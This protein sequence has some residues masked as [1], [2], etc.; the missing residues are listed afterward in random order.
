MLTYRL[1][2]NRDRQIIRRFVVPCDHISHVLRSI[3]DMRRGVNGSKFGKHRRGSVRLISAK[4]AV[5]DDKDYRV[6]LKFEANQS[7][8]RTLRFAETDSRRWRAQIYRFIR[9]DDH[10]RKIARL[11]RKQK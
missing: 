8:C 2:Y 3:H 10:M 1:G 11:A 4:G 9:Y 7:A 5:G 6:E